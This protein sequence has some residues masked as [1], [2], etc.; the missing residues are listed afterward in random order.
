[1]DSPD[2]RDRAY[3]YWRLL[4]ADP[5]T[6]K[7]V[8]LAEKPLISEQTDLLEPSVLNDL[9]SQLGS[10]ATVYHR[11]SN[12]FVDQQFRMQDDLSQ[13]FN[14]D[15]QVRTQSTDTTIVKPEI[16]P[17]I[18]NNY[19]DL[20]VDNFYS[21]QSTVHF[22]STQQ[23]SQ[24]NIT[25]LLDEDLSSILEL[26]STMPTQLPVNVGIVDDLLENLHV[27]SRHTD[28]SMT[29]LT[30]YSSTDVRYYCPMNRSL[31]LLF[32]GVLLN[33]VL[34]FFFQDLAFC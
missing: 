9:I 2:L 8:V 28:S 25:N 12:T 16:S 11:P 15:R 27:T 7:Q 10:L 31:E 5:G 17:I 33:H 21:S 30:Q 29:H 4:S 23:T 22:D 14:A 13:H 34:L 1:M 24:S 19:A 18:I 26:D 32:E 20:S 3:I 6:A